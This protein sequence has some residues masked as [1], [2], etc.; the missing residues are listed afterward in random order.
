MLKN[1]SIGDLIPAVERKRLLEIFDIAKRAA[2]HLPTMTDTQNTP[3]YVKTHLFLAEKAKEYLAQKKA[4]EETL[5]I[6]YA[7][8]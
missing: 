4:Y 6:K 3:E 7:N 8:Q 5:I 1:P 2:I